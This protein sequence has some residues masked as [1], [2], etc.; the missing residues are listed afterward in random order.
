MIELSFRYSICNKSDYNHPRNHCVLVLTTGWSPSLNYS[1]TGIVSSSSFQPACELLGRLHSLNQ[2]GKAPVTPRP[3]LTPYGQH[4]M[5]GQILSNWCMHHSQALPPMA[6]CNWF[7]SNLWQ[8][9]P[10]QLCER[11]DLGNTFLSVIFFCHVL[12]SFKF[13]PFYFP[14][15]SLT[16]NS[17]PCSVLQTCFRISSKVHTVP[18]E[19]VSV[20]CSEEEWEANSGTSGSKIKIISWKSFLLAAI[21]WKYLLY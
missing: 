5:W 16:G 17:Y 3:L 10:D 13:F 21:L 2:R 12:F 4:T 18:L 6:G 8:P 19:R 9:F 7:F 14:F 15:L 20:S 1:A 11:Q